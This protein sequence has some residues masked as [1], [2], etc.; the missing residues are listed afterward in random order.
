LEIRRH[1][2]GFDYHLSRSGVGGLE[3]VARAVGGDW[4]KVVDLSSQ[5]YRRID[6]RNL[7]GEIE[8]D[9]GS[10]EGLG[11]GLF[12]A[13]FPQEVAVALRTI[14]SEFLLL[15]LEPESLGVPWELAH[16]GTDFLCCRFSL[17]RR[18]RGWESQ[19]GSR[20]KRPTEKSAI[21]IAS[22]PTG[23]LSAA[24]WEGET[25]AHLLEQEANAELTWLNNRTNLRTLKAWLPKTDLLH[26]CGHGASND[27]PDG[28]PGWELVDARFTDDELRKIWDRGQSLPLLVFNNACFGAET[29]VEGRATFAESFLKRG[30]PHYI[31]VR[32]KVIDRRGSEFAH[33]FYH[34]VL[35]RRAIGTALR[36]ARLE[37]RSNQEADHLTWAQ[38]VL[39]GD[40]TMGLYGERGL[41]P[42]VHSVLLAE[43]QDS[44]ALEESFLEDLMTAFPGSES[45]RV[46]ES[47]VCVTFPRPSEAVRFALLLHAKSCR[48]GHPSG[49]RVAIGGGEL[50]V[51]RQEDSATLL[52]IVGLPFEIA[53]SLLGIAASGQTLTTR[54]VFDNARAMIR[55]D[56]IP[57]VRTISWLDHGTYRFKGIEDP[58]G[59]REVGEEGFA[60]LS[61]PPN[62]PLAHRAISPDDEPVLGWRPALDLEIPTA[63]GWRLQEKLGEG[64]FGEV[65]R[66]QHQDSNRTRVFKFCFRADRVRSLKR[67]V[68]LFRILRERLG[69]RPNIVQI[70]DVYFDEPPYF[71]SM[72]DVPGLNLGLWL[73]K[74]SDHEGFDR[75][76]RLEIVAK[77]ADAL[78]AAHDAGVIHRD[79]K[80]SNILV[81]GTPESPER[82][83]IKLADFG[84]GQVRTPQVLADV[85]A[86]GFTET[87]SRTEMTSGSGSRLYM[88]PELLVGKESSIR[89]DIYSLGVVLLQVLLGDCD[90]P[91]TV[92][93]E[94]EIE[95]PILLEDL[96]KCLAGDSSLRFNSAGEVAERLRSLPDRR[97][98]R[99]ELENQLRSETKR[100]RIIGILGTVTGAALILALALGVGLYQA[101]KAGK[102]EREARET[103]ERNLYFSKIAEVEPLVHEEPSRAR[104]ILYG[105]PERHRGW[106]WGHLVYG[107]NLDKGSFGKADDGVVAM[108]LSPD[109]RIL[110]TGHES[111]TLNVWDV[112]SIRTLWESEAQGERPL[113]LAID[114]QSALVALSTK[115]R[116]GVWDLQTQAEVKTYRSPTQYFGA[117]RFAPNRKLLAATT[118]DGSLLLYDMARGTTRE[119]DTDHTDRIDDFVFTPDGA[120]IVTA[121]EDTCCHSIDI[122]SGSITGR[123]KP[124][125][126]SVKSVL[127]DPT[128]DWALAL[129]G[130]F[131]RFIRMEPFEVTEREYQTLQREGDAGMDL[132]PDGKILVTASS[133]GRIDSVNLDPMATRSTGGAIG[134]P[135]SVRIGPEGRYFFIIDADKRV[136]QRFTR[137]LHRGEVR[138]WEDLRSWIK[139]LR[140]NSGGNLIYAGREDGA[141]LAWDA[142]T[143]EMRSSAQVDGAILALDSRPNDQT[144]V[145]GTSKGT[146]HWV[147]TRPGLEVERSI[148]AHDGAINAVAVSPGGG[149]LATTGTDRTL[150]IWSFEKGERLTSV[151][152]V[153]G[154]ALAY[155]PDGKFLLAQ[156]DDFSMGEFHSETL[157]PTRKLLGPEKIVRGIAI[158]PSGASLFCVYEDGEIVQWS[159]ETGR[160]VASAPSKVSLVHNLQ[161]DPDKRR[162]FSSAEILDL[163]TLRPLL[164]LPSGVKTLSPDG[165]KLAVERGGGQVNIL[166]S[167]PWK[168]RELSGDERKNVEERVE[169]YKRRYWSNRERAWEDKGSPNPAKVGPKQGRVGQVVFRNSE[170]LST[171]GFGMSHTGEPGVIGAALFN[172]GLATEFGI[173]KIDGTPTEVMRFDGRGREMGYRLF[174]LGGYMEEWDRETYTLLFDVFYPKESENKVRAIYNTTKAVY[175]PGGRIVPTSADLIVSATGGLGVEGVFH[176]NVATEKWTRIA[177]VVDLK[178]NPTLSKFIDGRLVGI[179]SLPEENKERWVIPY[180]DQGPQILFLVGSDS[181]VAPCYLSCV[182]LR[183]YA[184]TK[185]EIAALGG[186]SS[187]GIPVDPED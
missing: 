51:E 49:L 50:L 46:S 86:L 91:L 154:W 11:R 186:P 77:V 103:A 107:C 79:I 99:V 165:R 147:K 125:D 30:C 160:I 127:V 36:L 19:E 89:T 18:V 73:Q 164:G 109:G 138:I 27:S 133:D 123:V 42:E 95:D 23:D 76:I 22:N 129:V 82:I 134:G 170:P 29:A 54:T 135:R 85:T 122:M 75:S 12:Q 126:A 140:F 172:I 116:I 144:L 150:Q 35:N 40:P 146:L 119:I 88:A 87:Y 148:Q 72:E 179:Q 169:E 98:E 81:L 62:S 78:Q 142:L 74:F 96:R 157:E 158:D 17:G 168:D 139:S 145:A 176:G 80:P 55:G 43:R 26:Y 16:D 159:R 178:E 9:T 14:A 2:Q 20:R 131:V 25:L 47:C 105:I 184:M 102:R 180:G 57:G 185:E 97:R 68:T 177:C 33:R 167:F 124:G 94:R 143:G 15:D 13:A 48:D 44:S 32:S 38:Y 132:S 130:L 37:V 128:G 41:F 149:R 181:E 53:I 156:G 104:Q 31:G 151:D 84:I 67:E 174:F 183:D 153:G 152:S 162:L 34:H 64:G 108:E 83:E 166:N 66:A 100:K 56:E 120:R 92:D 3:T 173:P 61:A 171:T 5:I 111:G 69:R 187:D 45:M 1:P 60:P 7:R 10:L 65:W 118:I 136:R 59:V 175:E 6:A 28:K 117:L 58:I 8:K 163:E 121:G 21:L 106:E 90:R 115:N 101:W 63:R 110:A 137:D 114:S 70:Y 113:A 141:L 52:G 112:D 4:G 93:W 182:Q 71:I 24:S 39:Y 161:V 155:S